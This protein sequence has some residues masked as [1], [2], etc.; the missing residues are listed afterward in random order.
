LSLLHRL[1][2]A[3]VVAGAANLALEARASAQTPPAEPPTTPPTTEPPTPPPPPPPPPPQEP[4]DTAPPPIAPAPPPPPPVEPDTTHREPSVDRTPAEEPSTES[5]A[6]GPFAPPPRSSGEGGKGLHLRIRPFF[7]LVGGAKIDTPIQPDSS[8]RDA[9]AAAIM[10][11]DFG[12]RGDITDWASFES[13]IMANGGRSLHGTS[14][15]DGQAALQV[16]KQVL[17]LAKDWWMFE[18]GR[19]IDEASVDYFSLHVADT[20]LQDTATRDSFLFDGFNLGNGV[21]GTAEILPGL[22]IGLAA[23]AGNPTSTSSVIALGG[24]YPPYSRIYFQAAQATRQDL[25]GYPDDQF[26]AYVVTP[27]ILYNSKYF[28]SRL[29]TQMFVVDPNSNDEISRN[30]YGYNLRG[31][32]RAHLIDNMFS[33]YVN[34]A[35]GRNDVVDPSNVTF[36]SPDKSTAVSEG[37]GLD[38]NYQKK[39]G[40]FNGIG[41]QYM[42]NQQKT[43]DGPRLQNRYFNVGTTY[44]LHKN[45]AAGA[46]FALWST[47]QAGINT[48]GERSV[49]LT[50]RLVL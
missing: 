20:F 4:W 38:F 27:S 30:L 12:L 13:E 45:I 2:L 17:H 26:Q 46:R 22:R 6:E 3:L 32:L 34:I 14:V 47:E 35:Y 24:A 44:W 11:A 31:N 29:A 42:Q 1:T 23:N 41:V 9:R 15:Y 36:L 49:L 25:N 8:Q 40:N 37:G 21:R 33:P 39:H 19:V 50:L 48:T 16:R 28:E 5:A 7:S 18:V 10:I 43:G